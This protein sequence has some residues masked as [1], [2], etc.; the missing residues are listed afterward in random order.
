M[1][2]SELKNQCLE[3]IGTISLLNTDK[4]LDYLI[5]DYKAII[6]LLNKRETNLIN[7]S[8]RWNFSAYLA[9]EDINKYKCLSE[10]A[11]WHNIFNVSSIAPVS[12]Y[13]GDLYITIK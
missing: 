10:Y 8:V 13:Y 5:N 2:F 1:K 3:R 11:M 7:Y 6:K 4:S 9:C 12:F